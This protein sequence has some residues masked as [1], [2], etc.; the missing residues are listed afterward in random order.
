[1][2]VHEVI[3]LNAAEPPGAIETENG[4]QVFAPVFTMPAPVTV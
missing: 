1:L 3:A 4:K 2:V